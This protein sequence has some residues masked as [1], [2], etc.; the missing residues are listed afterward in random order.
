LAK[1][2]VNEAVVYRITP[3]VEKLAKR[4]GSLGATSLL[5]VNSVKCLVYKN[6]KYADV[7]GVGRELH[8]QG[9]VKRK[10]LE[11]A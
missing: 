5:S 2:E 3:M 10:V 7:V 1:E 6:A 11:R 4:R 8:R 9:T